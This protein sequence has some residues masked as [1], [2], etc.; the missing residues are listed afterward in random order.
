MHSVP[1]HQFFSYP[2]TLC[3][4]INGDICIRTEKHKRKENIIE[5]SQYMRQ[6]GHKP[7]WVKIKMIH[8]EINGTKFMEHNTK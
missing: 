5:L 8:Y 1:R 3:L 6:V 2:K 4:I 7:A